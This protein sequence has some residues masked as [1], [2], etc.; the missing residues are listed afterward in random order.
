MG[1]LVELAFKIV[2]FTLWCICLIPLCN[3]L[4]L[5]NEKDNED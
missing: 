5:Y 2:V 1:G 4:D 3:L